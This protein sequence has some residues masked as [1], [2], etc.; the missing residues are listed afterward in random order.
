MNLCDCGRI[1]F[2]SDED[3]E[4][5]LVTVDGTWHSQDECLSKKQ[6]MSLAKEESYV[7]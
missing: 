2:E 6:Q 1:A 5:G 4:V 3:P 7:W